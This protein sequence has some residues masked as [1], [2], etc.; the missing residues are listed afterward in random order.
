MG[1]TS[2]QDHFALP[3]LW[4]NGSAFFMPYTYIP[5]MDSCEY[6]F[7]FMAHDQLASRR[8]RVDAAIQIFL[9]SDHYAQGAVP[10]SATVHS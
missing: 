2:Q 6:L 4:N 8:N 9:N 3:T 1:P 10:D 7:H 5:Q